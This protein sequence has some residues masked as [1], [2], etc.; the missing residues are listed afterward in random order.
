MRDDEKVKPY[1]GFECIRAELP[2]KWAAL[3]EMAQRGRGGK[4][5]HPKGH[6]EDTS[7]KFD[8]PFPE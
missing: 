7:T 8:L 2:S 1:G 6:R 4:P 3:V 5:S